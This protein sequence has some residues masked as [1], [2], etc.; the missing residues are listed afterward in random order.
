MK[1]KP[2]FNYFYVFLLLTWACSPT[3]IPEQKPIQAQFE[4]PL[5]LE[6]YDQ[7][8]PYLNKQND[9]TYV[10]N[11]WATWCK[12]CVKE[13]PYFE[14]LHN[15]YSD[16]KVKVIL[17]SLDFPD[18]IENK[19]IPFLKEKQLKSD[20]IVFTDGDM[21]SWIPKISETWTGAIPATLVYKNTQSAFYEQSFDTFKE[22]D[23][24]II[25]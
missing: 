24:I 13:L 1:I 2:Y 17:V 11:F 3:S 6:K 18:Q 16:K 10:I 25:F 7:F 15:T 4:S 8:A 5:I 23:N 12:P 9:T 21:N 22:L 14:A 20:V 19:L